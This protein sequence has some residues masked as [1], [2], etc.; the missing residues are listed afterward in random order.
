MKNKC[1]RFISDLADV[2]VICVGGIILIIGAVLFF[3]SMVGTADLG[4]D[5]V[6]AFRSDNI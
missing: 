3:G 4:L 1:L 5:E 6:I 2:G